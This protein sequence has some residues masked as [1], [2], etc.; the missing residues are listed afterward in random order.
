M[1]SRRIPTVMM[2]LAIGF[3]LSHCGSDEGPVQ[4]PPELPTTTIDT[5]PPAAISDLS[6]KYPTADAVFLVWTAPGDDG[7]E[8]TAVSYDIRYHIEQITEQN[9]G[10]ATQ[11]DEAPAPKPGGQVETIKLDGLDPVTTYFFAI[12][13]T[14]D[15]G[16][17][18][19]LS[20]PTSI[21][22]LQESNPPAKV[23]DLSAVAIDENTVL[24]MWTA[25]G[26]DGMNGTASQY[27]IRYSEDP[28]SEAR[29]PYTDKIFSPPPAP[30]PGGEPESL[31]VTKI[32]P[33]LSHYF[34]LKA[35]D[36]VPN[37]SGI[38]NNAYAM[39]YS[40]YLDISD[41]SVHPGEEVKVTFRA[42][43]GGI[44]VSLHLNQY[45]VWGCDPTHPWVVDCIVPGIK[46]A[47]GI[48]ELYY[49]FST[50]EGEYLP[51]TTYYFILCY[52]FQVQSLEHVVFEDP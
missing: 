39:G 50:G 41:H 3:L 24:L 4:P 11:F 20:N 28:I 43:G 33:T 17:V 30:K 14:D 44:M 1:V 38:S 21:T 48:Y 31:F 22:T 34:V 13:T 36:E 49:D 18:S 9:W 8:G 45:G 15:E 27:Q 37:W 51:K 35:A 32:R 19:G 12:K 16:N 10:V 42:P 46:Y 5:V 26:D 23:T 6:T 7:D 47:E 2:I 40:V 52:Q 29:W 25:P